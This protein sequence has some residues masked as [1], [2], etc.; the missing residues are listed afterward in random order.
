MEKKE[1]T[2]FQCIYVDLVLYQFQDIM[3]QQISHQNQQEMSQNQKGRQSR[4]HMMHLMQNI[5]Q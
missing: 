5:Q 4:Q 2:L 3:E 1:F